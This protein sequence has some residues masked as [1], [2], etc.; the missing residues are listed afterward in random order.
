MIIRISVFIFLL[1]SAAFSE[2]AILKTDLNE[3]RLSYNYHSAMRIIPHGI[4]DQAKESALAITGADK[5]ISYDRSFQIGSNSYGYVAYK[6]KEGV[7]IYL[8]SCS[9]GNESFVVVSGLCKSGDWRFELM[10]L[11]ELSTIRL[12]EIDKRRHLKTVNHPM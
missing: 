3:Y 11:L 8:V 12:E 9:K 2:E 7:E 1:C 6:A 5:L 4:I 10:K